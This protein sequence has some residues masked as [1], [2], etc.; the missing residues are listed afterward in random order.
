MQ[1]LYWFY[2]VCF[3]IGCKKTQNYST[4]QIYFFVF[5][6]IDKNFVQYVKTS[7][8]SL[9]TLLEYNLFNIFTSDRSN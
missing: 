2:I 1:H 7:C 5:G 8:D 6:V 4:T 3:V 9:Y